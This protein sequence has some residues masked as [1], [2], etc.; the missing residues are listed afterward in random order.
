ML[1]LRHTVRLFN[2]IRYLKFRQIFYRI[3]YFFRKFK[4]E[5]F[6]LPHVRDWHCRWYSPLWQTSHLKSPWEF[7]FLSVEGRVTSPSD[8][9]NPSKPKLWL[10]HLHYLDELNAY[11]S[12]E[13]VET[14][15]ALVDLWHEGNPPFHGNGW[16]P[17]PL[18]LRLVNL[19]KWYARIGVEQRSLMSLA[20]Q[21]FTLEKKLEYHILGNHLLANAKALVFVGAF[22]GGVDGDRWMAKGLKLLDKEVTEQFLSDGAHFELSPMYHAIMVWDIC[23]LIRLAEVSGLALLAERLSCWREIVRLGIGWLRAMVHP[24]GGISFFNDAT[25]GAAPT[26]TDLNNYA[27]ELGCALNASQQKGLVVNHLDA[28]GYVSIDLGEESRVILDVAEL[29]PS[30]QPGH[31]HADTLSFEMSLYGQ[32][33][34]VNPGISKYGDDFERHRQRSTELHNTVVVDGESSSE[35]WSGFRVARRAH[36][37]KLNISKEDSCV[38]VSAC[39]DGYMRLRG[40]VTHCRQWKVSDE[41]LVVIDRLTGVFRLARANL[42][43]HPEVTVVSLRGNRCCLQLQKGQFVEVVVAGVDNIRCEKVFWHPCFGKSIETNMLKIVFSD[44]VV[45]TK[46]LWGNCGGLIE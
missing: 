18:S 28:S 11:G 24:D 12:D 23:D 35:V 9:N 5:D 33:L 34:F 19:V 20:Q 30:Y 2:T 45:T 16:E 38:K 1:Y 43:L 4:L 29:G 17:Y 22:L 25:L 26:F 6:D 14:L 40:K 13:R 31:A 10:Y 32:R 41:R 27:A 15:S 21:A 37:R 42:L 3:Y 46:I 8:W 7:N 44:S 39:H 36:P